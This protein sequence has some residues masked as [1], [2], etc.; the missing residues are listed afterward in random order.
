MMRCVIELILY[1]YSLPRVREL[2]EFIAYLLVN[3]L[4]AWTV[5]CEVYCEKGNIL[6]PPLNSEDKKRRTRRGIISLI[7]TVIR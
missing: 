5:V 6:S 2:V 7:S 3:N 1:K 4:N